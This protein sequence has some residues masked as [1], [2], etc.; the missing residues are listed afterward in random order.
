MQSLCDPSFESLLKPSL[1]SPVRG[2]LGVQACR[3]SCLIQCTC[4]STTRLATVICM[5]R[6]GVSSRG[7]QHAL[8][9]SHLAHTTP[10]G[11]QA[12]A[13][14]HTHAHTHTLTRMCSHT[15]VLGSMKVS[16]S[17][18]DFKASRICS[19]PR[20]HAYQEL[21]LQAGFA[22]NAMQSRCE[23]FHVLATSACT[24]ACAQAC[25]T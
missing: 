10:S 3:P 21:M 7:G 25:C 6:M 9:L 8:G 4:T 15:S 16:L 22:A 5:C 24:H 19:L 14:T 20:V 13:H 23:D 12:R 18:R 2:M 1:G 17:G 11:L